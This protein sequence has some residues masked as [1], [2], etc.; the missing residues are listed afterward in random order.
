[1][2]DR[3]RIGKDTVTRKIL[4]ET[5]IV[6]ISGMMADM[7]KIFTLNELGAFIWNL[8]DGKTTMQETHQRIIDT[9]DIDEETAR[10]DLCE[11]VDRLLAANLIESCD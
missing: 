8:L 9:Y 4:D 3:Y 10:E 2:Q 5:V 11:L 7:E 1:M 6:P